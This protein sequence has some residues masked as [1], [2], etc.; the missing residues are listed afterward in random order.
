MRRFAAFIDSTK[1]PYALKRWKTL[2]ISGGRS[3]DYISPWRWKLV[4]VVGCMLI[5][6]YEMHLLLFL[7]VG[8]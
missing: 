8:D 7:S 6:Y 2:E 4:L 1:R 3:V 5:R